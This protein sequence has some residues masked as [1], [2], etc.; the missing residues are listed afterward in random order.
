MDGLLVHGQRLA[1]GGRVLE[2]HHTPGHAPGHLVFLDLEDAV[3]PADKETARENV[4]HAL[5]SYDWT[6]GSVSVRINGLDTH[7][8]Y[9]DIV[10]VVNAQNNLFQAQRDYFGAHTYER[11]DRKRGEFFHTNWTGTGGNTSASTYDV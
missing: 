2:A 5:N 10:D 8:C 9:R 6:G 7:Y 1:C 3:A 4:I 11:I